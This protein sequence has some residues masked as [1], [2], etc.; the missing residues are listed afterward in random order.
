MHRVVSVVATQADAGEGARVLE[1]D[2]TVGVLAAAWLVARFTR[3]CAYDR[4]GVRL[5][6]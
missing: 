6:G 1:G 3:V 4:P 2:M 5:S